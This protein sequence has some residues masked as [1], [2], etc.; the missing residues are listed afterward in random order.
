MADPTFMTVH[1]LS[2]AI[3]D[4]S[5]TSADIVE[6]CLGRIAATDEKLHAFVTVYAD[7]ARQAAKAAELARPWP[8]TIPFDLLDFALGTGWLSFFL[9]GFWFSRRWNEDPVWLSLDWRVV[10]GLVQI[11]VVAVWGLI[12]VET[13][14]VWLFMMPLLML[15]VGIELA[16]WA[17]RARGAVYFALWV[18]TVLVGQNM[19]FLGA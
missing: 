6:C 4:G 13:A 5:L 18:L 19:V 9:V 17:A 16:Q 8:A 3:T 12:P 10:A 14:R 7:E 11:G 1:E 2:A 15:P